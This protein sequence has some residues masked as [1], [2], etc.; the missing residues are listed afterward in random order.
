MTNE[1]QHPSTTS[2]PPHAAAQD[3]PVLAVDRS[4]PSPSPT[5]A[6]RIVGSLWRIRFLPLVMGLV[7][8]GGIVGM[9]FQPPG[10]KFIFRT[11]GLTPGG[12]TSTP[13]AVPAPKPPTA[14][15]AA[16]AAARR[17][18]TVVGLGKLVPA[19]DV[20]VIATPYGSGD[21]RIASLK[22]AEGERVAKGQLIAL[23]DNEAALQALV[24]S[25]KATVDARAAVVAQTLA[26]VR[27]SRD[28]ARAGL[29][30]A[31][32]T[33]RNAQL[34]LERIEALFR[35]GVASEAMFQQRRTQRDEAAREVEKARATLSRWGAVE[36][37]RHPDVVLAER[38]LESARADLARVSGDL[39]R[40]RVLA[41]LDATVLTIHVR[42]GERP[43]AKGI[44]N[45]GNID[46]MTVEIEV[47][48]SLI[49][50]VSVGDTVEVTAEALPRPLGGVVTRI[51]LEVGR[52]VLTDPN[53]AANTDARVVK[54]H[55]DLLPDATTVAQR[56]TNL[57]VTARITVKPRQ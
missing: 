55:A 53:P 25:A 3:L 2:R 57:Q 33:S 26:I 13:I 52:Q 19:S 39:E 37:E 43:G 4:R 17:Q 14:E 49:G 35:K 8:T 42:P 9:Y 16:A 38:N 44:M 32:A 56:F 50:A 48:Q 28:E 45:L 29:E 47:Y 5:L 31:E 7:M 22:V 6:Q 12:G 30:R 21:A 15:E 27:A 46:K 24:G 40:A 34:D 23:L 10:L 20:V 36:P 51:G 11:F 18:R 54:V 41:P 1:A